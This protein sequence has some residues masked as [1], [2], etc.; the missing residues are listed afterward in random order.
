MCVPLKRARQRRVNETFSVAPSLKSSR[1]QVPGAERYLTYV[2]LRE[3]I[4]PR[5]MYA[6]TKRIMQYS[7][8]RVTGVCYQRAFVFKERVTTRLSVIIVPKQ[9]S[10]QLNGVL[11]A[12]NLPKTSEFVE[13]VRCA[14]CTMHCVLCT[15]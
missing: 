11:L 7:A 2:Q 1:C 10:R 15:M 6:A 5:L 8:A 14:Q 9:L 12:V 4:K 13:C 3:I